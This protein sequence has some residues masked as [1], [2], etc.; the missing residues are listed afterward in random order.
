[1]LRGLAR[2]DTDGALLTII[3]TDASPEENAPNAGDYSG[4][5][6]GISFHLEEN[7]RRSCHQC[8]LI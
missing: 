2:T 3:K 8:G 5:S 4:L 6:R 7:P 1:M